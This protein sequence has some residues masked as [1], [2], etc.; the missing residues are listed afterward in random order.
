MNK[1]VLLQQ[2]SITVLGMTGN[3]PDTRGSG[4]PLLH[5]TSG[6][7]L[8]DLESVY[9]LSSLGLAVVAKLVAGPLDGRFTI[10]NANTGVTY[11][12]GTV[13]V[14][15]APEALLTLGTAIAGI[16]YLMIRRRSS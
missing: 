11:L 2:V 5:F 6:A 7:P 15:P 13:A 1:Q 8:L 16:G 14:S 10:S 12:G 9:D 3:I 4:F